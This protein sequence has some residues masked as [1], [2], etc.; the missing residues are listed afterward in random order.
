MSL[1]MAGRALLLALYLI[2]VARWLGPADYGLFTGWLAVAILLGTLSGWGAAQMLTQQVAGGQV[3]MRDGVRI[4]S[5]RVVLSSLVVG[6]MVTWLAAGPMGIPRTTLAMLCVAELLLF[7]LAQIGISA[8]LAIGRSGRAAI[9]LC[10]I[11][12]CRLT[13]VL[14]A[15]LL[16][17]EGDANRVALLHLFGS[18]A[19]AS[20][21][22]GIARSLLQRESFGRDLAASSMLLQRTAYVVSGFIAAAYLEIDKI[23]LLALIT[24]EE[25]GVYT[26][27]FRV[28]A[29]ALMPALALTSVA[30]PQLFAQQDPARRH[31]LFV[32]LLIGS[33]VYGAFAALAL[34]AFAPALP[35]LF[36][37]AF[38]E[39][40]SY[41]RWLAPWP[42]VFS[43]TS[44]LC[45]GLTVT[46]R[47]ASRI[48]VEGTGLVIVMA[49][50]LM[51]A[52]DLGA[53]AAVAGFAVAEVAK[54]LLA[55][56]L[57]GRIARKSEGAA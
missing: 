17:Y 40:P 38:A 49:A 45:T 9:A 15:A 19:G 33:S 46:D 26:A 24:P 21:T 6:A 28:A 7:P 2:L 47:K 23:L 52:G 53:F 5:R 43:I 12:L 35:M 4:A 42:L 20:I 18:A 22:W 16:G 48:V 34:L 30:L 32:R 55:A 11:P 31:A 3:A 57:L 29:T 50:C 36:G 8:C 41:L 51:F 37:P 10:A 54:L 44:A 39:S 13:V 1:G 56:S 14:T 27:A 25:V